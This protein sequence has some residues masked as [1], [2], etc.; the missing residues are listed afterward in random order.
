MGKLM[1]KLNNE[2]G[3][4][5]FM[6]LFLLLVCVVVSVVIITVATTSVMHVE[7]NKTSN[8]EYLA[9]ASAAKLIEECVDGSEY[10]YEYWYGSYKYTKSRTRT[11]GWPGQSN[12]TYTYGY[13][14]LEKLTEKV[15]NSEKK[16]EFDL[17]N[18]VKSVS[19]AIREN[20]F[21]GAEWPKEFQIKQNELYNVNVTCKIVHE[22]TAQDGTKKYDLRFKFSAQDEDS[23][24]YYM[25]MVIPLTLTDESSK[26]DKTR[27]SECTLSVDDWEEISSTYRSEHKTR[28][29]DSSSWDYVYT[30][31]THT[32]KFELDTSKSSSIKIAWG[33]GSDINITKGWDAYES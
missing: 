17:D 32:N 23:Y 5:I 25:S 26:M 6:A 29:W 22:S 30:D 19:Q 33:S 12:Y 10:T 9:C 2:N 20:S 18:F 11:G 31:K 1:R 13:E 24:G 16:E 21:E 27:S 4:S 28:S 7:D 8:Q 14:Y 15:V 3:K